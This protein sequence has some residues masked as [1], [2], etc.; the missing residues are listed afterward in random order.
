MDN[1]SDDKGPEP[2]GVT[3]ADVN[4]RLL[5][6]I[7]LERVGGVIVYDV[8]DPSHPTFQSWTNNRTFGGS[9]VGPDSGPEGVTVVPATITGPP[10]VL[11]GNEVS[12]TVTAFRV[13]GVPSPRR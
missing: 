2:E 12:G 5:A 1:R 3:V 9:E 13:E 6:F 7:T 4:G 10:L 11:V 8:T